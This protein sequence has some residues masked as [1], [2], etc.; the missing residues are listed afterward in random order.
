MPGKY[1]SDPIDYLLK[2]KFGDGFT[3]GLSDDDD[4]ALA[5]GLRADVE[6]YR[7]ELQG[8]ADEE[9]DARVYVELE[10]EAREQ[11]DQEERA[12]P[13]NQPNAGARFDYW[14][15]LPLWCLDEA[16][17]LTLERDPTV[18]T[19]PAVENFAGLSSFARRFDNL[20]R[21]VVR[22]K[23]AGQL[24]DPVGP[25]IYV[26]WASA[27]GVAIPAKLK[28]CVETCK[29]RPTDWKALYEE[30]RQQLAAVMSEL[31]QLKAADQLLSTKERYTFLKMVLGMAIRGYGY[32]P[33]AARS[34]KPKEIAADLA[35]LGISVDEDTV[36]PKLQ[37][38]FAEFGDLLPYC[39]DA[40]P[41]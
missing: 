9:V 22:A 8:L 35:D 37:E 23:E 14:A 15:K 7:A 39:D 16:V 18:V 4:P 6:A 17:A 12:R 13:F 40:K 24:S 25:D 20:R 29:D 19:W 21:L 26:A 11:E 36:R 10:S 32:D 5:A 41:R 2:R 30:T 27:N 34:P 28:E 3:I 33:R 1:P 31:E 38:A